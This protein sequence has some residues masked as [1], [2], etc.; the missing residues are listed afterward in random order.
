MCLNLI[1]FL[2]LCCAVLCRA[3]FHVVLQDW[4]DVLASP[5]VLRVADA[6]ATAEEAAMV[7]ALTGRGVDLVNRAVG[8]CHKGLHE[9]QHGEPQVQ[10]CRGG[11]A[12]GRGKP[13]SLLVMQNTA[14][15]AWTPLIDPVCV[16]MGQVL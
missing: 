13:T 12:S 10:W 3:T 9:W 2:C 8:V 5:H 4:S 6:C 14:A 1:Y 16:G 15:Q 11:V 7:A